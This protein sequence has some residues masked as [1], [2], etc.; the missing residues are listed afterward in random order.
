MTAR[1]EGHS[2]C[3]GAGFTLVELLVT[4]AAIGT[5]IGVLLP[6]I[7]AA[8]EAARRTQ[9]NNNLRNVALALLMHHEAVNAF[10]SG[11]WGYKWVGMPERG[12]GK[13]QP[14]GWIYSVLPYIEQKE[15]HELGSGT[16]GATADVL[17]SRRLS[18]PIPLFV[19]P[20]RRASAA[21]AVSNRFSYMRTP[22][23]FGTVEQVARTDYT[24]NSGTSHV[25]ISPGPSTLQEGDGEHFWRNHLTTKNFSGIS[26]LR[27]GVTIASVAD[28]T[29]FTY[30]VGEKHLSSASYE[31]GESIG[32]NASLYSGYCT[33]LHR[34]AGSI[35]R[36]LVGMSPFV[37]PLSD[38]RQ[39]DAG[40]P[41]GISFGSAHSNGF[42]MAFCD[43]SVRLIEFDVDL[44]L[45][46]R[47]AH[48]RDRGR[49]LHN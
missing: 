36:Q 15:L 42:N 23:P 17:Y 31:N 13:N 25:F 32:D 47:A 44:E 38:D 5:L 34:F 46:F 27:T 12:S 49:P 45:H 7:Q 2:V 41:E 20:S 30:L 18:T 11:G 14:G 9:C 48:R 21:W 28:G 26:H 35:E 8:R 39:T 19:C 40:I 4:M 3:G 1:T 29:S 43:G 24:I 10:P 6:A 16:S 22:K 37:P 33:D